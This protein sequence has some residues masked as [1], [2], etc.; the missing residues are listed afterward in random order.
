M[1][2]VLQKFQIT[3]SYGHTAI[4]KIIFVWYHVW[5]NLECKI[6]WPPVLPKGSIVITLGHL[7]IRQYIYVSVCKYLSNCFL[8]FPQVF[9]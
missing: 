4:R 3:T 9:G 5:E 8:V 7:S 2:F 1:L 6:I